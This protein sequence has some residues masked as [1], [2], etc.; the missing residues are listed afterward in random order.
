[1]KWKRGVECDRFD[2]SRAMWMMGHEAG[3]WWSR[4]TH[5]VDHDDDGEHEKESCRELM[6]AAVRIALDRPHEEREYLFGCLGRAYRRGKV[7]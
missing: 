2:V 1:M 5:W 4:S 7:A 3:V 6:R